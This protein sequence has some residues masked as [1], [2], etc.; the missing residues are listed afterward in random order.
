MY[1]PG[2]D[3][4]WSI[5]GETNFE[6]EGLPFALE[7]SVSEAQEARGESAHNSSRQAQW[8]GLQRKVES[9]YSPPPKHQGGLQNFCKAALNTPWSC[10]CLLSFLSMMTSNGAP[11]RHQ[12]L[13]LGTKEID[14]PQEEIETERFN[15]LLPH[16]HSGEGPDCI[17][18][19]TLWYLTKAI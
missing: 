8:R 3:L 13:C 15:K 10:W 17:F 2:S 1:T 5:W 4:A 9:T 12:E 11:Y 19:L 7:N 18:F 14:T 16:H 6:R